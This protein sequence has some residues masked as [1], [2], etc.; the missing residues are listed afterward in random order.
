MRACLVNKGLKSFLQ[1]FSYFLAYYCK[2][3]SF[4]QSVSVIYCKSVTKMCLCKG[5]R[6]KVASPLE[7][8]L[9]NVATQNCIASINDYTNVQ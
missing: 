5:C 9:I 2:D 3:R 8:K 6:T 4:Y 7:T 1:F